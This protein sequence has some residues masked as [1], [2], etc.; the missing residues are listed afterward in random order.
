MS[1]ADSL[2]EVH[3]F[4][5]KGETEVKLGFLLA[6]DSGALAQVLGSVCVL[7]R[8]GDS[9]LKCISV[10][11]SLL[12]TATERQRLTAA[13]SIRRKVLR[14]QKGEKNPQLENRQGSISAPALAPALA[15]PGSLEVWSS[16]YPLSRRPHLLSVIARSKFFQS[17]AEKLK[18]LFSP[19]LHSLLSLSSFTLVPDRLTPSE[20]SLTQ[21]YTN[22]GSDPGKGPHC[23]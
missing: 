1:Q 14:E 2:Q 8:A 10:F 5:C 21:G 19:P 23:T 18:A 22:T 4:I 20:N 11:A 9:F 7:A 16:A 3:T 12:I 13:S 15:P 6:G 17:E